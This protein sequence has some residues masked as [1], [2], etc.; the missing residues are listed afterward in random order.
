MSKAIDEAIVEFLVRPNE[1]VLLYSAPILKK[2][3]TV[4]RGDQF[5]KGYGSSQARSG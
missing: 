2:R 1:R 4:F 3:H 5:G